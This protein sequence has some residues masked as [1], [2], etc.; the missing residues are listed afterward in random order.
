MS[1][2]ATTMRKAASLNPKAD[3]ADMPGLGPRSREMLANVGIR[4][5]K[6]LERAGSVGAYLMVKHSGQPASL[7]LL[8]GL[9]SALTGE[10]WQTVAREH[11]T[12][13]LLAL[14]EAERH[15]DQAPP[16]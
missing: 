5:A 10:T 9:E 1:H 11:R 15:H 6:D 8:W 2:Q 12:S 16:P 4:S 3:V 14:E 7:N 13:L